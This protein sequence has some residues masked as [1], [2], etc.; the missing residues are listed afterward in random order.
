MKLQAIELKHEFIDSVYELY[1]QKLGFGPLKKK[2]YF[3]YQIRQN[4]IF[5]PSYFLPHN[6]SWKY[7]IKN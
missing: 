2:Y 7:L 1:L 5:N 4:Y 3:K 6:L